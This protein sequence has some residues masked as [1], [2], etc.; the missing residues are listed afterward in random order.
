MHLSVRR[1]L[2]ASVVTALL[3]LGA[4]IDPAAAAPAPHTA[5]SIY[6][7]ANAPDRA[8]IDAV[9]DANR[10]L[11]NLGIVD[12]FGFVSVR[13]AVNPHHF[14]TARA[15]SPAQVTAADVVEYDQD[16]R[17]VGGAAGPHQGER[18]ISGEVFRARP[19][20]N[21]VVHCHTPSLIPY[22]LTGVPLLPVT[23]MAAFLGEGV[24]VFDVS[25]YVPHSTLSV[26]SPLAGRAMAQTLAQHPMLLMR[27]HGAVITGRTVQEAVYRS[28]YADV[29]ARVEA[30][31]MRMG[32]PMQYLNPEEAANAAAAGVK[33]GNANRPW[34]LWREKAGL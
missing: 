4:S 16:S 11:A 25:R 14:F 9:V 18:F 29:A 26:N 6:A 31:S 34:S 24:P 20:V 13:S 7:P 30:Q 22:S 33:A 5:V 1:R 32:R 19:D 27:A 28:Y 15:M 21:V 23:H 17:P 8:A 3:C 12:S 2:L 10:V